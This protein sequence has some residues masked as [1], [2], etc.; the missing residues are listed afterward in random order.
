[1]IPAYI[2]H[3]QQRAGGSKRLIRSQMLTLAQ[4]LQTCSISCRGK[5]PSAKPRGSCR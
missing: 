4:A 2:L 5:D 1:M 3:P